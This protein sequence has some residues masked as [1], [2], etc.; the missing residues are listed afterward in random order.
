MKSSISRT[1]KAIG[2]I[3]NIA[4]DTNYSIP[5]RK[6]SDAQQIAGD[7]YRVGSHCRTAMGKYANQQSAGK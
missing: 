4:P 6:Y 1:L 5:A 3:L 2:S 7:W